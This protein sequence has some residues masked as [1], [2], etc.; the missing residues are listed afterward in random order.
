MSGLIITL[1]SALVAQVLW[2]VAAPLWLRQRPGSATCHCGYRL[3]NLHVR[4]ISDWLWIGH[5]GSIFL[6]ALREND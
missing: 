5:S 1:S 4:S 3:S 6:S 2:M